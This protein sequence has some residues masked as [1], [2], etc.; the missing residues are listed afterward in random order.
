MEKEKIGDVGVK[1]KFKDI[2]LFYVCLGISLCL[3]SFSII[4]ENYFYGQIGVL[5]GFFGIFIDDLLGRH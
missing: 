4:T 1:M 2:E 5:V 3:F